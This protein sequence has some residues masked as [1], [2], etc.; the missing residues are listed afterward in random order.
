MNIRRQYRD[1]RDM[2]SLLGSIFNDVFGDWPQNYEPVRFNKMI[3]TN[4]FPPTN[5]S[6]DQNTKVMVIQSALA[7]IHEDWINLSFDGDQ[8]KL[9]VDIPKKEENTDANPYFFQQGLK[10][11][12]HLETSWTVDPRFYSREDVDVA[13]DNGLLTIKINPKEDVKPKQIKLFGGLNTKK[14]EEKPTETDN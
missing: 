6:V 1:F 10:N 13:F 11:I 14:L 4:S 5:I 8:L 2:N 12:Q 3:S 7:G 9:V